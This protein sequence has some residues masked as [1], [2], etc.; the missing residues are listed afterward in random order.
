MEAVMGVQG[1]PGGGWAVLVLGL[2]VWFAAFAV[3]RALSRRDF[4]L[5]LPNSRSSHHRLTPRSGGVAVFTAWATGLFLFVCLSPSAGMT[6]FPLVAVTLLVFAVG[7]LDDRK[8]VS[9]RAKLATQMLA[10]LLFLAFHGPLQEGP[11]P[12]LGLTALGAVGGVLTV[13]WIVG[14]MNA[15]NFIDGINGLAASCGGFVLAALAVAATF[16]GAP[17]VGAAAGLLAAA[18]FGFLPVN[19]PAGRLFMGDNGSQSVGYIAAALGVL[20]AQKTDGVVS[21]LFLPTAAAPLLF[22]VMFT[23]AH[24]AARGRNI[25]AAHR[26]HLYQL[27]VRTGW[28]HARVTAAYLAATALSTAAAFVVLQAPPGLQFAPMAV[29]FLVYLAPALSLFAKAR[30]LGLLPSRAE[31]RAASGSLSGGLAPASRPAE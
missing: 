26:E 25:V 3:A 20:A 8:G 2:A 5:D 13:L 18:L 1:I 16:A 12:L 7:L 30:R 9:A 15:Y 29:L 21:A 11:A 31:S 10:A 17:A 27:L 24:R 14:F 28:T 6:A 4:L 22:D 19:F 23:V